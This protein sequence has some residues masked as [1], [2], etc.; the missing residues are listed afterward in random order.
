MDIKDN[1]SDKKMVARLKMLQKLCNNLKLEYDV[2]KDKIIDRATRT[3]LSGKSEKIYK[4]ICLKKKKLRKVSS[5]KGKF[6]LSILEFLENLFVKKIL[7]EKKKS[8]S[9]YYMELYS[10]M[11][12]LSNSINDCEKE[13]NT[14]TKKT[15]CSYTWTFKENS[16]CTYDIMPKVRRK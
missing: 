13:I 5:Y 11:D 1:Y 8:F 2:V 4:W 15:K 6:Y 7:R 14:I 12:S 3:T 9:P 16:N 10:K